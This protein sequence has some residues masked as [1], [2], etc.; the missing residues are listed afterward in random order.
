MTARSPYPV[1]AAALASAGQAIAAQ[2]PQWEVTTPGGMWAAFWQS[3]DGRSRRYIVASSAPDLLTA[4]RSAAMV[5]AS[6]A[7]G[8]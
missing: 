5:S 4:L 8:S 6:P 7:D 3:A 2:F 1:P